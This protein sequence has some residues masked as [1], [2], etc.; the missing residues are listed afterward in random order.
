MLRKAPG[1][2]EDFLERYGGLLARA[3]QRTLGRLATPERVDEM[4][5]EVCLRLL[6][7]D[8]RLLRSFGGRSAFSTWLWWVARGVTIDHLRKLSRGLG[9]PPPPPEP[10]PGPDD[11]MAAAEAS[12]QVRTAMATLPERSRTALR[13]AYWEDRSYAEIGRALSISAESVGPFLARVKIELAEI[14]K[15]LP[16]PKSTPDRRGEP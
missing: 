11:A 13:M 4:V 2:W 1:A 12:E 15:N 10:A 8:G 6:S 5:S 16:G 14:L 7:H 3:C 9:A